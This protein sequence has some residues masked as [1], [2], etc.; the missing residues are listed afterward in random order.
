SPG[1]AALILGALGGGLALLIQCLSDFPLHIP[2]VSVTAVILTATLARRGL[3]AGSPEPE[4]EVGPRKMRIGP[5]LGGVAMV[6]LCGA[7][8]VLGVRLARVE[9][10]V[11]SVGLPYSGT[12]MPSADPVRLSTP[13]LDRMRD[14]LEAALRLRPNWAEGH[15]RRGAAL[16]GLYSNLAAEWI[17]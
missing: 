15:L 8:M 13:E 3:E 10:L 5:L 9:A 11:R 14:A 17:A 12:V 6:G 7:V 16:E 4:T 2:G 1:D